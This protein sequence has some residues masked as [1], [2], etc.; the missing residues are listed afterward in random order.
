MPVGAPFTIHST[1]LLGVGQWEYQQ[2]TTSKRLQCSWGPRM[3]GDPLHS[4]WMLCSRVGQMACFPIPC[5][6]YFYGSWANRKTKPSAAWLLFYIQ[7]TASAQILS[8]QV[9][10]YGGLFCVA[11]APA[12]SFIFSLSCLLQASLSEFLKVVLWGLSDVFRHSHVRYR[13]WPHSSE[14]NI[15]LYGVFQNNHDP[16]AWSFWV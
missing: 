13:S 3:L 14:I 16:R 12:L 8:C 7:Y 6:K 2:E 4:R 11:E 9:L 1:Q 15:P 5:C 10:P